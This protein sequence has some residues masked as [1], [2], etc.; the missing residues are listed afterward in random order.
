MPDPEIIWLASWPRSGNT[1][2]RAILWHCFGLRSGSLYKEDDILDTPE[3]ADEV[4]VTTA[5]DGLIGQGV[6][7]GKTHELNNDD[8]RAIYIIRDG[9]E[10]C[11]SHWHFILD[12]VGVKC[13]LADIIRTRGGRFG[14]WSEHVESW[15]PDTRA[16]TLLLHYENVISTRWYQAPRSEDVD[17]LAKFLCRE[18][19]GWDLPPFSHFHRLNPKFFR[20]GRVDSWREEMTGD[21]LKLFWDL[22]GETMERYGYGDDRGR[23]FGEPIPDGFKKLDGPGEWIAPNDFNPAG[24]DPSAVGGISVKE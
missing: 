22:H 7:L 16:G 24:M 8:Y 15:S 9:R 20:S 17:L 1:L 10:A 11:V 2:L 12:I 18:R 6:I 14:S 23:F 13:S 3:L 5:R 21:D 19:I 4:G